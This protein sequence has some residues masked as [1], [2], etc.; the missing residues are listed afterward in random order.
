MIISVNLNP[1]IDRRLQVKRI[2]VGEMNRAASVQLF[3]GDKAAPVASN[4]REVKTQGGIR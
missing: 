1:A 4:S 2:A 3:P